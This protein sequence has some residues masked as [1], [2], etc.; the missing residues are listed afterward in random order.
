[1]TTNETVVVT[2]A[3]GFIAAWIVKQLLQRGY[4][5]RGTVR[6]PKDDKKV[7]HLLDLPGAKERLVLYKAELLRDG[8]FELITPE[9]RTALIPDIISFVDV[10][11]VAL[12]HI[13]AME[14]PAAEGRYLAFERSMTNDQMALLLAKL[15]PEYSGVVRPPLNG[16]DEEA[17][18]SVSQRETE[19]P[20][21]QVHTHRGKR[22]ASSRK[23]TAVKRDLDRGGRR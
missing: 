14:N 13:L 1:M 11:D 7:G 10:E 4:N 12:A 3:N 15:Y 18:L 21:S 8:D 23:P 22:K 9:D 17:F 5:V 2:G 19:S 6:N 20:G 16:M